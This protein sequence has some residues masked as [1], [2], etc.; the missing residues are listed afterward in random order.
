M[1]NLFD[2]LNWN[3]NAGEWFKMLGQCV[4]VIIAAFSQSD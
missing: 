2:L 3:L 1:A 4:A